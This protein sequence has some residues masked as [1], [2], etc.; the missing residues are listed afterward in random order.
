LQLLSGASVTASAPVVTG[1]AI[2]GQVGT[3]LSFTVS[4]SAANPLTF[5]LTGAPAGMTIGATGVVTW[6]A[7][8]AGTYSVTALARDTATSLIGQGV[9]TVT[10]APP[11]APVVAAAAVSGKAGSALSFT[12]TATASN[13]LTWSL[14]GAPA[15]M[16][17]GAGGVVSWPLPLAGTY[18]DTIIATDSKTALTGKAVTTVAIAAPLPPVV[19]A[20]SVSGRPGSALSFTVGVVAPNPVSFSL[21]GAPAGMS[22]S[23]AG[24]VSW[25]S[26]VLGSYSVTVVA[27]DSKTLLTGQAVMAI[28]IASAGP[29]ISAA[30]LTGVAGKPFSG[31]IGLS[32]PGAT[33]LSV[34][35]A[36]APLGMGFGFNGSAITMAW[37]NPVAG[38]YTLNLVAT[39]SAGLSARASVPITISAR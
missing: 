18:N 29:V 5:S 9:Y 20:G 30:P 1:A 39:D 27:R 35:I 8:L 7:P 32:A 21:T 14:S 38:A 19:S 24:V 33:S 10:V 11:P 36:G 12:A 31:S 22:I 25:A 4:A 2:A 17:I 26:P 16:T 34:S 28:K 13:A 3:A 37:A 15:G 6:P 23:G